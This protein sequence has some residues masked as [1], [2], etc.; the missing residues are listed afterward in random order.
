MEKK[1]GTAPRT[2][3]DPAESGIWLAPE[4]AHVATWESVCGVDPFLVP[5]GAMVALMLEADAEMTRVAG[6]TLAEV[7]LT[8]TRSDALFLT[9]ALMEKYLAAADA[10][11]DA[12]IALEHEPTTQHFESEKM[13]MTETREQPRPATRR[14][15]R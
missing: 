12:C 1:I 7:T 2:D 4:G 14:G 6:V 10:A 15:R 3:G 9:P 13:L 8:F 11:L 5:I